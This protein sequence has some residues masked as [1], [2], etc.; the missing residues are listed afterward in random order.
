MVE[1]FEI[2]DGAKEAVRGVVYISTCARETA[3][4][5]LAFQFAQDLVQR[6]SN[7]P[8]SQP[9]TARLL[10]RAL[11][12]WAWMALI[13]R[14]NNVAMTAS[15][16]AVQLVADFQIED[17]DYLVRLD[18]THAA[19]LNGQEADARKQYQQFDPN[20]VRKDMKRL[21]SFGIC[22]SLFN[23]WGVASDECTVSAK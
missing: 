3:D 17:L 10:A 5:E 8:V 9:E 19:L 22:Q 12:H 7:L 4:Q 15:D 16:R 6:L 13:T 20:D 14:R 1:M 11:D 18:H 2:S 23:E 21:M